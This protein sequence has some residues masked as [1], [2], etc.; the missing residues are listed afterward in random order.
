MYTGSGQF[1]KSE[2]GECIILKYIIDGYVA[3]AQMFR[4]VFSDRNLFEQCRH[5]KQ[6]CRV[7]FFFSN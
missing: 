1:A 2:G 7:T 3:I 5:L 6:A 4:I